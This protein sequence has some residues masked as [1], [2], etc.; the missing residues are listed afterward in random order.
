[1][2]DNEKGTLL[3]AGSATSAPLLARDR[4]A[5]TLRARSLGEGERPSSRAQMDY[6]V[7]KRSLRAPG[8]ADESDR[9]RA[10]AWHGKAERRWTVRLRRSW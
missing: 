5:A 3:G 8:A 1:M 10:A 2:P 4:L 7:A 6:A 9:Q